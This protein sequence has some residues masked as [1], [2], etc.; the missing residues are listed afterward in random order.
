MTCINNAR[1]P[2]EVDAVFAEAK[3][4]YDKIVNLSTPPSTQTRPTTNSTPPT[5]TTGD[6][7]SLLNKYRQQDGLSTLTH[8]VDVTKMTE[9]RA[10]EG[11]VVYDHVRPNRQKWFMIAKEVNPS[12][13]PTGEIITGIDNVDIFGQSLNQ[14]DNQLAA[15]A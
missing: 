2:S 1:I 6:F 5:T 12:I 3:S 15:G 10:R 13:F 9:I 7:G 4:A 11:T 8:N 14:T